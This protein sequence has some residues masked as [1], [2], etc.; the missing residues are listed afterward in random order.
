LPNKF[1]G[2]N[3]EIISQ[4]ENLPVESQCALR[5]KVHIKRIDELKEKLNNRLLV[6]NY[7]ELINNTQTELVKI[8]DFL[9]MKQDIP[10]PK[11]KKD[12]LDKWKNNLTEKQIINIDN[13]L[14]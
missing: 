8:K 4:Y 12:S 6:L 5:W 10:Y 7:E 3:K 14:K 2:I 13:I 1:L 9:E 11:V